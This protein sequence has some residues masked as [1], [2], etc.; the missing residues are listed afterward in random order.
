MVN[1]NA[2]H[3]ALRKGRLPVFRKKRA[4]SGTLGRAAIQ[5]RLA[6]SRR[7]EPPRERRARDREVIVFR[8]WRVGTSGRG[9]G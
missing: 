3:R 8:A 1:G 4:E 5:R 6:M 7:G 9:G 2:A